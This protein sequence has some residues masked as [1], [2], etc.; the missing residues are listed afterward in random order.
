M[1]YVY[2][3]NIFYDILIILFCRVCNENSF[4]AM[5]LFKARDFWSTV[6][7]EDE[8]FDVGC[9]CVADIDNKGRGPCLF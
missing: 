3:L 1:Y 5:S 8:E 6:V 7:G 2:C 9:I 4:V